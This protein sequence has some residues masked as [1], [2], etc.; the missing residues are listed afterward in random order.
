MVTKVEHRRWK[1]QW[2]PALFTFIL[3]FRFVPRYNK[4]WFVFYASFAASNRLICGT[5]QLETLRKDGKNS[6]RYIWGYR[7]HIAAHNRTHGGL[8][9]DML[10]T[11]QLRSFIFTTCEWI[12]KEGDVLFY[13]CSVS[14]RLDCSQSQIH[15]WRLNA[16]CCTFVDTFV[17]F[18]CY[19]S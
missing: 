14:V 6:T 19:T 4:Y 16:A 13:E 1:V 11:E 15:W 10:F 7:T 5:L 3:R 17:R 12:L 9:E 8:S 2:S 18:I